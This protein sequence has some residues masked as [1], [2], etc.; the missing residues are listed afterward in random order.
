MGGRRIVAMRDGVSCLITFLFKLSPLVRLVS[1][2][3]WVGLQA[4][5]GSR[6]SRRWSMATAGHACIAQS[7]P[8][9]EGS[10]QAHFGGTQDAPDDGCRRQGTRRREHALNRVRQ[11][12]ANHCNAMMAISPDFKWVYW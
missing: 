9:A 8:W 7:G 10:P 4:G 2:S 12:P 5:Q 1:E 3:I 6:S 11:Q